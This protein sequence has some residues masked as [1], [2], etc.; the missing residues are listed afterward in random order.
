MTNPFVNQREELK[1]EDE[2]ILKTTIKNTLLSC[3]HVVKL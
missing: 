1:T 3:A 2:P